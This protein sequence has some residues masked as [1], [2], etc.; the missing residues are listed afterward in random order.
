MQI[1]SPY[2][3]VIYK[4]KEDVDQKDLVNSYRFRSNSKN[5][6]TRWSPDITRD[7][8]QKKK[9]VRE[10]DYIKKL[11]QEDKPILMIQDKKVFKNLK[12]PNFISQKTDEFYKVTNNTEELKDIN[13]HINQTKNEF[14]RGTRII[15]PKTSSKEDVLS[16]G[17]YQIEGIEYLPEGFIELDPLLFM[18]DYEFDNYCS[19]EMFNEEQKKQK[20]L[21]RKQYRDKDLNRKRKVTIYV[22]N[23][24]K[25]RLVEY[26]EEWYAQNR[27]KMTKDEL[28]Y[29]ANILHSDVDTISKLQDVFL[30]KKKVINSNQWQKYQVRNS[31]VKTADSKEV[32]N[33][34]KK[35]FLVSP[36]DEYNQAEPKLASGFQSYNPLY[37]QGYQQK[38]NKK[39]RK[40]KVAF[41]NA[42]ANKK[43]PDDEL[44][45]QEL[46]KFTKDFDRVMENTMK[47]ESVKAYEGH[48]VGNPNNISGFNN[49]AEE[50]IRIYFDEEINSILE[51][52][53]ALKQNKKADETDDKTTQPKYINEHKKKLK[54]MFDLLNQEDDKKKK[55]KKGGLKTPKVEL[56]EEE[57]RRKTTLD[58]IRIDSMLLKYNLNPE[59]FRPKFNTT[60]NENWADF[61]I[62]PVEM[63][64]PEFDEI[65]EE[66]NSSIAHNHSAPVAEETEDLIVVYPIS[67]FE[68]IQEEDELILEEEEK[69]N[70]ELGK[71]IPPINVRRTTVSFPV[72]EDEESQDK[73]RSTNAQKKTTGL[74]QKSVDEGKIFESQLKS[75]ED[76]N[77]PRDLARGSKYGTVNEGNVR[78]SQV[79]SVKS[80]LR[81]RVTTILRPSIRLTTNVKRVTII[82]QSKERFSEI[83]EKFKPLLGEAE[84]FY[85]VVSD[86]L[87]V[88]GKTQGL[89]V[90]TDQDDNLLLVDE[91]YGETCDKVYQDLLN[92]VHGR[93]TYLVVVRDESQSITEV[94]KMSFVDD[95]Y[96]EYVKSILNA[97]LNEPVK[98]I[99]FIESYQIPARVSVNRQSEAKNKKNLDR[100]KAVSSI[101]PTNKAKNTKSKSMNGQAISNQLKG[102]RL[103]T[104]EGAN[105]RADELEKELDEF[106][107]EN[108][109]ATLI[110]SEP[111]QTEVKPSEMTKK[112]PEK[113]PKKQT[114]ITK[115][116]KPET[117]EWK[118][119]RVANLHD[120]DFLKE[121]QTDAQHNKPS[122]LS[123]DSAP[124]TAEWK[125]SR[126]GN[127]NDLN[128][129]REVDGRITFTEENKTKQ[130]PKKP[131]TGSM[132]GLNN[133]LTEMASKLQEKPKDDEINDLINEFKEK[134]KQSEKSIK[135]TDLESQ[136]RLSKEQ[137][138]EFKSQIE[139]VLSGARGSLPPELLSK[140]NDEMHKTQNDSTLIEHFYEFCRE[141][142]PSDQKYKESVLFVSLFYYFLEKR[143]MIK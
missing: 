18:D 104:N 61:D 50:D 70:T 109:R 51:K 123:K 30:Q 19:K 10:N 26:F 93:Q 6:F 27:R 91:I 130:V 47:M 75:V 84:Y 107:E 7:E 133:K 66:K 127:L 131:S 136:P 56:T 35:L 68:P 125:D 23:E 14:K 141:K 12:D 121:K 95:V 100:P 55:K 5:K 65:A 82:S 69:K 97:E 1:E 137:T 58:R 40:E 54:V 120:V 110:G 135:K 8:V 92:G 89:V 32:P 81:E 76:D 42:N 124:Q 77:E 57:Q 106:E 78:P 122:N 129:A 85:E 83:T 59:E 37:L 140:F 90:T 139:K 3:K 87:D 96:E 39:H 62:K 17:V 67:E 114:T 2:Q 138:E 142:L 126:L 134:Q 21:R 45:Q 46:T 115:I 74:K 4:G 103:T 34:L 101:Q 63:S 31:Y 113:E 99:S 43:N 94:Y 64:L 44:N 116:S 143:Q 73:K 72:E 48:S 24:Y 36:T 20:V 80:I 105:K 108:Q 13:E 111:F 38:F 33:D 128:H 11:E 112:V 86:P 53:R 60:L 25:D 28:E 98:K 52:I 79:R 49:D 117:A 9:L 132:F 29:I 102:K 16:K 22:V 118:D 15:L 41:Q 88:N 119:S 71:E